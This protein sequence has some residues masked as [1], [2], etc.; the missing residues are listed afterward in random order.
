MRRLSH[1]IIFNSSRS[2][3]LDQ[4]HTIDGPAV[5]K[6][7]ITRPACVAASGH[8]SIEAGSLTQAAMIHE[9]LDTGADASVLEC[10]VVRLRALLGGVMR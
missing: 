10:P 1:R 3:P 2:L 9:M 8:D 5:G 4:S 6:P 7:L